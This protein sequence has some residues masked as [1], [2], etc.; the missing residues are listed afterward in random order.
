MALRASV[1]RHWLQVGL[2]SIWVYIDFAISW[3]IP[4]MGGGSMGVTLSFDSALWVTRLLRCEGHSIL[5]MNTEDLKRPSTWEGK[6]WSLKEFTSEKWKWQTPSEQ[7]P[8]KVLVPSHADRIRMETVESRI[9]ARKLPSGSIIWLDEVSSM[10]SPELLFYQMST[11]LPIHLLVILGHELC[12]HFSLAPSGLGGNKASMIIPSAT[13]VERIK[14]YLDSLCGSRGAKHARLALCYVANSALSYPEALLSAVCSF[15]CELHGYGLGSVTLNERVI[16]SD[17]IRMSLR[18]QNRYPDLMFSFAPVGINYEGEGH[19]DLR[20]LMEIVRLTQR[21]EGDEAKVAE[22]ALSE[23]ITDIRTKYVDDIQRDRD[24]IARGR[25]VLRATKEDLAD[26][27]SLDM[28]IQQILEIAQSV[29]GIDTKK[30]IEMLDDTDSRR[31]RHQ[32]IH[33]LL[34]FGTNPSSF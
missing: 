23:K 29:F 17:G 28:L 3:S 30:Q 19:L 31:D 24:L 18:K 34:Q 15:P 7:N 33:S 32:L 1:Y 10:V 16:I 14:S 20:G 13:S 2:H 27:D 11:V 21:A 5:E 26:G 12:G 9:C 6:R 8:L 22:A 25:V 4:K